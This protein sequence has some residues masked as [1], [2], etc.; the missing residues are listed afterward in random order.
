M[1]KKSPHRR[2]QLIVIEGPDRVGKE[3]QTKMLEERLTTL[4]YKVARVEVPYNDGLTYRVI[5]W[6][7]KNGLAKTQPGLFQAIQVLNRVVYQTFA[8]PWLKDDCDFIIF[9]RWHL[10]AEVYGEASGVEPSLLTLLDKF[11]SKVDL[12][13]VLLGRAHSPEGRDVYENDSKF[14]TEVRRLYNE[15]AGRDPSCITVDAEGTIQSV[16]DF[17]VSYLQVTKRI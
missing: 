3:T 6:M 14:Q 11:I 5:Y 16:H 12:T 17:I 2:T 1:S 8:L 15:Y 13:F 10:S 7:L 9:D 4:G